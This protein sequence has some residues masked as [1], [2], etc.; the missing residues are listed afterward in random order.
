MS[1]LRAAC[2]QMTSGPVMAD[3]LAVAEGLI[4]RAAGEGAR[5][6][7]TP[8]VTCHRMPDSQEKIR[9]TPV[10]Q[11]HPGPVR[12]A[13][14]AHELKVWILAGSFLV[15]LP[16]GKLANRS[17]LFSD[18]G[19]VAATYDKIHL[20]DVDLPGG[21]VHRESDTIAPGD[22]GVVARTPWGGVGLSICYD[23]RFPALY[24]ALARGGADILT[25]PAAFTVPTGQAHWEILLRA[26]A[27]ETGSF[28][29]APAQ[30]GAA[31]GGGRPTWG[32]SMIVGPWGEILAQ[33]NGE[34]PGVTVADLDMEA[35]ARA[36]AAIPALRHAR[37]SFRVKG[38]DSILRNEEI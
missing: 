7:A 9:L 20:F 38:L 28:V 6:V 13:A 11:D 35:V 1:I 3:N 32:H 30:V 4:R 5:F 12:F 33:G 34:S 29:V 36:R 24:G 23:I 10:L 17:F 22:H 2:V 15:R 18:A 8:E 27:I 19:V 31:P 16:S 37:G 26:R 25:V 14:L 21:E